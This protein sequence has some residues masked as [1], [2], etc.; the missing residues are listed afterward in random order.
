MQWLLKEFINHLAKQELAETE[1]SQ[2]NYKRLMTELSRKELPLHTRDWRFQPDPEVVGEQE[3]WFVSDFDDSK[4]SAIKCDRHWESQGYPAL[5]HW[6]WYRLQVEFD[7]DWQ[8]E[9]LYLNF[10]GVDDHYRLWVNGQFV[11]QDGNIATKETAFEN[12]K[13]YNITKLVRP[14]EPLQI[15]IAVYDWYGAGGIFRPVTISTTPLS[16]DRPWLK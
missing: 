16:D 13:S 14:G 5:D 10:T 1:K 12:R 8:S 2:S 7:Q 3:E 6:A 15:A 11:G 9:E 4:W